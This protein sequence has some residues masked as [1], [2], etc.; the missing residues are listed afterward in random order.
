ME[1][2]KLRQNRAVM[3]RP[4]EAL[5]RLAAASTIGASICNALYAGPLLG[6]EEGVAFSLLN[7]PSPCPLLPG[8]RSKFRSL[9]FDSESFSSPRDHS[10]PDVLLSMGILWCVGEVGVLS[11]S[12]VAGAVVDFSSSIFLPISMLSVE[13]CGNVLLESNRSLCDT[14]C[15]KIT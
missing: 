14:S 1:H 13:L 5:R 10:S 6:V 8:L 11:D 3:L 9:P 15:R 4:P 2:R 12:G 7:N